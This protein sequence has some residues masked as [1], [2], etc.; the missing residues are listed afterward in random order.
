MR[1]TFKV[2]DLFCGAGGTSTGAVQAIERHGGRIELLA[3]NHWDI[4]IETHARNHPRAKHLCKSLDQ[5]RPRDAV[6]GEV[7]LLVASP[8]CTHHSIARGGKPIND[9]SRM[10]AFEVLRWVAE[11]LPRQVLVENVKEFET[12]GPIGANN[13]PLKNRK[14]ET[15]RAW[16]QTLE[17]LGYRVDRRVLNAANYGAATTRERMFVRAVRGRAS[18]NWPAASHSP[19]GGAD[20]FGATKPWRPARDIIDWAM[21]SQ[22]I[23]NRKKPLASATLNRIEMGL[24]K[25]GG[26]HAEPF[27]VAL[28]QHQKAC[29][30]DA[31]LPV[32][33]TSGEDFG[34]CQ[35]FVIGQQ[36]GAA[37]RSTKCPIPT[38]ATAGAISLVQPQILEYYGTGDTEP[39]S[40]PLRTITTKDRFGLV[41]FNAKAI[42]VRFRML[43]PHELSAAMGFP[44]GYQFAGN[45]EERVKQIGNAVE[46]NQAEALITEA[47]F[48]RAVA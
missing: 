36:S 4:A 8:E 24:K 46:V 12:W 43:Q 13:R 21:P 39:V 10:S 35:P 41:E 1:K 14:G 22:S 29:P 5:V 2:V 44:A 45:R 31:P 28:R 18:I 9:Q 16:L 15:F 3:V 11:L 17:S 27:L 48:G 47:L 25:F 6:R 7:D 37:P 20:L 26:R 40:I 38:I 33:A 23:F 19:T 32:L 42:D 34:V 30:L